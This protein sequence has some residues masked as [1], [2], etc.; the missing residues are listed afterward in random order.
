M[1]SSITNQID[2]AFQ[3]G[4]EEGMVHLYNTFIKDAGF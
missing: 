4:K 2:A 1:D 3:E